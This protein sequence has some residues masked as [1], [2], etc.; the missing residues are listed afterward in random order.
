[1]ASIARPHRVFLKV[2]TSD[3]CK[4]VAQKLVYGGEADLIICHKIKLGSYAQ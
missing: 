2:P 3:S 1:M 4:G